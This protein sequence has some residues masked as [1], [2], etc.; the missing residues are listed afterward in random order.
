MLL[1]HRD[2][3]DRLL[4]AQA[5][6]EGLTTADPR[7]DRY[8]IPVVDATLRGLCPRLAAERPS[9]RYVSLPSLPVTD[10]CSAR[11]PEDG[12]GVL[13]GKSDAGGSMHLLLAH[14][15][16]TAAVAEILWDRFLAPAVTRKLDD[17][18]AGEGR[19]LF[20]LICGLHDVG[21]ASPAF[22]S[23]APALAEA[24]QAAGLTW[25]SLDGTARWHHTL[26]GAHLLRR[27]L[28]GAGWSPPAQRWVLPLVAGHHGRLP[29]RGEWGT[30][31][32]LSDAQGDSTWEQAQDA[33]VHRVTRELG[34][35]LAGS[36]PLGRP[37][38]AV[39]LALSGAVIMA[40]WI[41]SADRH[42]SGVSDLDRI[43]MASARE[44]AERAWAALGIRGGW[45]PAALVRHEDQVEARFG[46]RARDAQRDAVHLA[47]T[48]PAPGL[49][50]V[51]APMGEGKT[52]A[53]LAAAEV[54][55]ARFGADGVFVGMPTQ[56]T[57]DAMYA[58]VL[59]WAASVAPGAPVGLL[60]GKR[61]FNREWR[62]LGEQVGFAKVDEYG[63]EDDLYGTSG[64][65]TGARSLLPA[66]WLLGPKRGLLNALTVGTVDQL[67]YAATRTKH[68]MLR[69]AGLAGRVVVLD[70]VH[71]YDIYMSQFLLETLRWL[72]DAGVPVVLLSATLPPAL[73]TDLVRA[74]LQGALQRRDGIDLSGLRAEG[75]P[76][77]L[78]ACVVDGQPRLDHASSEPWR[79]LTTVRLEPVAEEPTGRPAAVIAALVEALRDGGCAL[80]IR[81]TVG[82]AQETYAAVRGEFG[83]DAV[84]LHARMT[85]GQKAD[86]TERLLRS[87]GGPDR[88]DA[89]VRPRR[90]VVVATQL[91]EQS[92]DVDADLLVTDLAPIDLLLQR[93]GRLHRHARPDE[94]RPPSV[95]EP[96]VLISG[97]AL[98]GDGPPH[99][100]A[101]SC[102][103]YG[104]FLLLRAAALV[105]DADSWSVPAQVPDLVAAGYATDLDGLPV[106]WRDRAAEA[107]TARQQQLDERRS[108]AEQ[109]L[110]SPVCDLGKPTLD[111]LHKRSVAVSEDD[112]VVAAV[113]D[114]DESIEVVLVRRGEHGFATLAGRPLGLQGERAVTDPDLLNQVAADSV[115]LPSLAAVSAAARAELRPLPGWAEDPWLRRARALELDG[116]LSA[117]LGGYNFRY[118]TELGL[119]TERPPGHR[120]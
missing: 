18:A 120:R 43:S 113:R 46:R 56:A 80:V 101:G 79:P 71:A 38:R 10:G 19:A 83:D 78:T 91:A 114:G 108:K 15:L 57:S 13:W 31:P 14:L 115:R 26:A 98:T 48:M 87:L 34:L 28:T 69:H 97:M 117:E 86:R 21:K 54:L 44:R 36:C 7:L 116:D 67:L 42:F 104:E 70:E 41:A 6:A 102:R 27:T 4:V 119:V 1:H 51:E 32:P 93:I 95:R 89:E 37:H 76:K 106:A 75:Y 96:R 72:A 25:R 8:D 40:D 23:K 61:R 81:N 118:S 100:P 66:E 50:I 11:L 55:A 74:Y 77:T 94:A 30:A 29:E 17:C 105:A 112:D 73:R 20:A 39:Q 110:L 84:L 33:L 103:I 92:F 5:R 47:A 24:V 49:V 99:F 22:Q 60:H 82:R 53:A 35:D 45:D 111:G 109:F 3:F 16:D 65:A 90:L 52:E 63:C 107:L 64:T 59:E 12:L 68:V 85:A 9:C 88:P 58:R 62:R 2:P